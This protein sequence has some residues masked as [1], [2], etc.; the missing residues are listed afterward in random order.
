M[1]DPWGSRQPPAL[2]GPLP[3]LPPRLARLARVQTTGNVITAEDPYA[4]DFPRA[5]ELPEV[6]MLMRHGWRPLHA[7]VDALVDAVNATPATTL[8]N[9]HHDPDGGADR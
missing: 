6:Q 5:E 3:P 4:Q 2:V 7:D 8:I 1:T 9:P